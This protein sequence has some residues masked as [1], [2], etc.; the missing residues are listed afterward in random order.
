MKKKLFFIFISLIVFSGCNINN[1]LKNINDNALTIEE[2]VN[3]KVQEMSLE[4]K[5][6]QM[7][8]LYYYSP[9]C[10]NNLQDIVKNVKPGGFILFNENISS[11]E[12]TLNFVKTLQSNSEIPL[13][14]SIDQ[15]G[16][17]VQRFSQ[18]SD[19]KVTKIPSMYSLGV[20][21]DK[22]L[23]YDVGKVMAEELRTIGVN[24][25][26]A[27]V[28]DVYSNINNTVIGDRSFSSSNEI[29]SNLAISLAKGLEDNGVIPVYKHFPG[30]G[31]TDVDS[32]YDLPVIN[33]TLEELEKNELIP[34]KAAIDNDA[35]VIMIGHLAVPSITKDNKPAS[36][37]SKIINDLL[38]EKMGFDGVVVTDA[39]NM[40]ALTNNYSNVEIYEKASNAGVDLLLMP[41]SS[42]DTINS[43]VKS[44]NEGKISVDRINDAVTRIL[45]LK[46]SSINDYKY[47]DKS[48]LNND[49]H[50]E[51]I[52]RVK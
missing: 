38:K 36:L 10:D 33:K 3:V 47:L 5:I 14:I 29:V 6:A 45:M 7:L 31:D 8:I 49:S 26:F 43:I 40:K 48:Y 11:Y 21:N 13:F 15:E 4:E 17:R 34:F 23:A 19:E 12:G 1:N 51:V 20:K 52:N 37:S 42:K 16:G 24:M 28:V 27:P 2:K 22:T 35:K 44:V 30:H 50:K 46:Y 41:G 39:L 32:H 9:E 18:L 25:T